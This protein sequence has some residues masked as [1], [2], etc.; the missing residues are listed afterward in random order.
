MTVPAATSPVDSRLRG[1]DGPG[2][3]CFVLLLPSTPHPSGLT[4]LRSRWSSVRAFSAKAFTPYRSRPDERADQVRND[5][6]GGNDGRFCKFLI[7]S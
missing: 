6:A 5:G 3:G 2:V 4:S 1:N 7:Q